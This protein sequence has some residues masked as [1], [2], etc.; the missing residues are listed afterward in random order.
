MFTS[1]KEQF[2]HKKI[3]FTGN[4][5]SSKSRQLS[6]RNL[7]HDFI[8]IA[9]IYTVLSSPT[10]FSDLSFFMSSCLKLVITFVTVWWEMWWIS[11]REILMLF[12]SHI[13][14][15]SLISDFSWTVRRL[16]SEIRDRSTNLNAKCT[17]KTQ[18]RWQECTNVLM[19]S[20]FC[21]FFAKVFKKSQNIY[22]YYHKWHSS[23]IWKH[24]QTVWPCKSETTLAW[25]SKKN[26]FLFWSGYSHT[27]WQN[28]VFFPFKMSFFELKS[29]LGRM[30]SLWK[31]FR[32]S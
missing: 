23:S 31:C 32:S 2:H 15:S 4:I 10:Y 19:V 8:N 1:I 17:N 14:Q 21:C 29:A 28:N 13:L 18:H 22:F 9:A 7:V 20:L 3:T 25:F 26:I 6:P 12:S 11:I 16:P 24:F 30:T 5:E 27:G